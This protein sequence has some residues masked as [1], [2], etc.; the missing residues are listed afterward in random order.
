MQTTSSVARQRQDHRRE[1]ML[2]ALRTAR[3]RAELM[4]SDIDE[5]GLSL[6][7]G[8]ISPEGAVTWADQV[9]ALAMIL[10]E[11]RA[12]LIALDQVAA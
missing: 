8:M 9:G 7:F 6:K 11:T 5:I 10:P 3:K 1:F 2:A 4:I 12:G